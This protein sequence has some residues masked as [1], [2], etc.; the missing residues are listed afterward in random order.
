MLDITVELLNLLSAFRM[1]IDQTEHTL[2]LKFGKES[3]ELQA[4]REAQ[5][6]EYDA[7]FGYRFLCRLRNYAQHRSLP[8]HGSTVG[9]EFS[10][11]LDQMKPGQEISIE[12]HFRAEVERVELLKE[13]NIWS[14]VATEIECLPEAFEINQYVDDAMRSIQR[15]GVMSQQTLAKR[16]ASSFAELSSLSQHF[17][18]EPGVRVIGSYEVKP[19]GGLGFSFSQM[20]LDAVTALERSLLP[21]PSAGSE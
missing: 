8:L 4:F 19:N 15:L 6:E 11:P 3:P 2:S 12:R 1:F 17:P 13:R 20:D 9:A 16:I 10:P 14:T 21:F 5:S 18:P 7:V